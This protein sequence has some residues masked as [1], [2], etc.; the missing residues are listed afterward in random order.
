MLGR[1]AGASNATFLCRV[2]D[3]DAPDLVRVA[4][5]GNLVLAPGAG[6]H[7]AV[8]KPHAGEAPL[9]DFPDA[10]L[11]K[12]EVAAYEL[13]VALGWDAVPLTVVRDGPHGIGAV[14]RYVEHDPHRHYFALLEEASPAI[15]GQL[16]RMVVFDL[17]VNNADRKGGHVLVDTDDHVWLVDHGVTFHFE[18]KLRTVAWEFALEPVPQALRS[19]ARSLARQLR[20][21]IGGLRDRLED[22]LTA[23]EVDAL[24][25]RA[26]QVAD[27]ERFPE[28]TG[29]R[30]YPWPLL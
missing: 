8:Y 30:P 23:V 17:L 22:L 6:D 15:I 13:A 1:F 7:L 4:A 12:R 26:E 16:R 9:W 25:E 14:Q 28:P 3:H 21:G 29:P 11:Y 24:Q 2:G 27:L 18:L 20:T 5:D 19:A 10:A